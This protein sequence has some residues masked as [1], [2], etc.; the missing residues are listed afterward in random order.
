MVRDALR[1]LEGRERLRE[2]EIE[3]Y[4]TKIQEAMHHPA[5]A[6]EAVFSRLEAKYLA[7]L[8]TQVSDFFNL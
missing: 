5:Q 1:V 6:S 2:I 7:M 8:E 4:R 3:E